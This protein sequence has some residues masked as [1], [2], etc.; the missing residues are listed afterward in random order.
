MHRR[1]FPVVAFAAGVA[2]VL[3]A[4]LI[5]YA[6]IG[7]HSEIDLAHADYVV[8]PPAVSQATL[9][10]YAL[11]AGALA[12]FGLGLL[13]PRW[14]EGSIDPRWKLIVTILVLCGM[15]TGGIYRVATFATSGAN[16]GFGVLVLFGGP[17]LLALL[18]A[19]G[20]AAF[21]LRQTSAKTMAG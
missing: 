12:L 6:M 2:P 8:H 10:T 7:D 16:I 17:L 14:K 5:T 11:F 19:A 21:K 20:V 18:A 3:A 1:L 15:L 4:P 9:T 13:V